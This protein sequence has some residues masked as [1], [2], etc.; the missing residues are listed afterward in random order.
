MMG[1][2]AHGLVG[3]GL[4]TLTPAAPALLKIQ[5]KQ[6]LGDGPADPAIGQRPMGIPLTPFDP[7]WQNG[8]IGRWVRAYRPD[9]AG[10]SA[11]LDGVT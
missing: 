1:T 5:V 6:F 7:D 10:G 2:R 11:H 3:A 9:L 8:Q 4:L